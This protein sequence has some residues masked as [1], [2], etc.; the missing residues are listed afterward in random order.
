MNAHS[1]CI[2]KLCQNPMFYKQNNAEKSFILKLKFLGFSVPRP[3]CV[4]IVVVVVAC[5]A[6]I[7]THKHNANDE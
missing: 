2:T 4:A 7:E 6:P 5:F 3:G 1:C